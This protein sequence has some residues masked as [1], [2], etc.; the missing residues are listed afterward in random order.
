MENLDLMVLR[1]LRDWRLAGRR[2]ML[3]TVTRTWGSSPRPVGS[4]MA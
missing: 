4:I 3:V 1:S 2:A